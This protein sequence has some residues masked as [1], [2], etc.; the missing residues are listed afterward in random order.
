[1]PP[2]CPKQRFA[3]VADGHQRSG[4]LGRGLRYGPLTIRLPVLPKLAAT[5]RA[6]PLLRWLLERPG[7]TVHPMAWAGTQANARKQTRLERM[8]RRGSARLRRGAVLGR[9]PEI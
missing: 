8:L 3:A 7:P 6:L 2:M 9:D 1:V 5:P 4:R